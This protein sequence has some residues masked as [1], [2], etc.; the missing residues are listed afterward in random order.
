MLCGIVASACTSPPELPSPDTP[1]DEYSNL[2]EQ[3]SWQ[4]EQQLAG[5]VVGVGIAV[6]DTSSTLWEAGFGFAD[7]M[8]QVPVT[9][10]TVFEA[11]SIGKLFTGIAVMQLVE[12][13]RVD[14]DLP[15]RQYLPAFSLLP[16]VHD[17]EHWSIDQITPRTIM[18]QHSGIPGDYFDDIYVTE[19]TPFQEAVERLRAEPATALPNVTYAYSNYAFMV[20]DHMVK[21]VSGQPFIDYMD[22]KILRPAGMSASS[23]EQINNGLANVSEGFEKGQA[24]EP[25][26]INA[27][28]AGT[29]RSS[30]RD[31]ATFAKLILAGG[32]DVISS[33]SLAQMWVRENANVPLDLDRKM[34]L[35]WMLYDDP[36]L[37]RVAYHGGITKYFRSALVVAKDVGLAAAVLINSAEGDAVS[38]AWDALY[39]AAEA[40]GLEY[41]EF[42]ADSAITPAPLEDGAVKALAG[43]YQTA[44]FG[45]VYLEAHGGHLRGTVAGV[46]FE[47]RPNDDGYF[48][49]YF[50]WLKFF[51]AQPEAAKVYKLA[52]RGVDGR[53][54][55]AFRDEEE[56]PFYLAGVRIEAVTVP[57]RWQALAG[58]YKLVKKSEGMGDDATLEIDNGVLRFVVRDTDF[59][60]T[61]ALALEALDDDRAL[62]VGRGLNLGRLVAVSE[63]T[64][65]PVI[66][67]YG[68]E[69]RRTADSD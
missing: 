40:K 18:T 6:V 13:N 5:D 10:D 28:T 39:L 43:H 4:I 53:P 7:A 17:A 37:G 50:R 68:L 32:G 21:E 61:I 56:G 26:Y 19:I 66:S 45:H 64:G 55:A 52:F 44:D 33:D 47:L 29:L 35:S 25:V 31:L 51:W 34:G 2:R 48:E 14:L 16:P 1:R 42:S 24:R 30:S 27:V 67:I 54:I 60:T 41:G 65:A 62:I 59:D 11:G 69:Y 49:I 9:P 63:E 23:F 3:M 36:L 46:D 8:K 12:E 57:A 15:L 58:P 20:L 38:V 22:E